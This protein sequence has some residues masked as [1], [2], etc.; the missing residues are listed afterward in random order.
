MKWFAKLGHSYE[1]ILWSSKDGNNTVPTKTTT[2]IK[3]IVFQTAFPVVCLKETV[4]QDFVL[5]FQDS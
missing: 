2:E 4:E 1:E 3:A 5:D